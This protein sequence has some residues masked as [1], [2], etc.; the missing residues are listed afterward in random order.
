MDRTFS[1]TLIAEW[2]QL[3]GWAVR[4]G[5]PLGA[6]SGGGRDEADIVGIRVDCSIP[7]LIHIEVGNLGNSLE[8]NLRTLEKKFT[9]EKKEQLRKEFGLNDCLVEQR[10]IAPW[11]SSNIEA[12]REKGYKIDLLTDVI[13]QE[14]L[15]SLFNWKLKRMEDRKTKQLPTPPNNLWLIQLV[16]LLAVNVDLSNYLGIRNSETR[17][18]VLGEDGV[19][20]YKKKS[21]A[22]SD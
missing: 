8:K 7:R 6:K 15:P 3:D 13:Q 20:I 18:W 12:I 19:K 2:L 11:L 21:S 22:R 5:V 9:E 4:T 1:E 16:D 10:F 14:I 17:E